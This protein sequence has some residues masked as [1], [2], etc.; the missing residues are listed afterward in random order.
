M[1]SMSTTTHFATTR[2]EL[3]DKLE[4][5]EVGD[6]IDFHPDN[7]EGIMQYK[8]V[9]GKDGEKSLEIVSTALDNEM[10]AFNKIHSPSPKKS[11]RKPFSPKHK[12]GGKRASRKGIK[13]G[14]KKSRRNNKK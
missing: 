12:R 11:Y 4:Q 10:K 6:L 13:R 2:D 1:Y 7:Q 9:L 14:G 3:A 8:I 5:G